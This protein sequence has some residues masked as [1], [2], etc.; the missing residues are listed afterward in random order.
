[1][2][3]AKLGLAALISVIA[4]PAMAADLGLY[5]AQA[6]SDAGLYISLYG[7]AAWLDDVTTHQPRDND[8]AT[9]NT[10]QATTT[11]PR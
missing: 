10:T 4:M 6:N 8:T 3:P 11:A 5:E 1:V 9:R 2:T 7:G